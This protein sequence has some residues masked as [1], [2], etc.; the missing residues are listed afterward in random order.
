MPTVHIEDNIKKLHM[1]IEQLTREVFRHQGMIQI[2]EDFKKNGLM[3]IDL[4]EKPVEKPVENPDEAERKRRMAEAG[5]LD[6]GPFGSDD[7]S[8]LETMMSGMSSSGIE[9]VMSAMAKANQTAK[10]NESVQEKPE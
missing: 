1:N 9:K 3:T 10:E 7:P 8:M 5:N 6:F 2:F 4:P